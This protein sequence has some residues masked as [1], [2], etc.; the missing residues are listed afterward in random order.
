MSQMDAFI[1]L[2]LT[3]C[4]T[5]W[6]LNETSLRFY[7]TLEFCF[8]TADCLSQNVLQYVFAVIFKFGIGNEQSNTNFLKM[9]P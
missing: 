6:S 4:A 1:G 3:F 7:T 2:R 5:F 9:S 8:Q